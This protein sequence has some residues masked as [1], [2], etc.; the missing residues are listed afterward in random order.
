MKKKTFSVCLL[1]AL[2]LG[3][4]AQ[5]AIVDGSA[6]TGKTITKIEF[7]NNGENI[8]ITYSD[9]TT[10]DNLDLSEV[11]ILFNNITDAINYLNAVNESSSAPIFYYD[12]QGRHLIEAPA[13]GLFIMKKGN[14]VVK[15]AKN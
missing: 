13:K 12:L 2:C 6:V 15:V 1:L 5:S 10:S 4:N 8:K 3:T 9:N 7:P 11:T 14:K